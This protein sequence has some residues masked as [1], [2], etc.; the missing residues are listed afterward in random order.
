MNRKTVKIM[1]TIAVILVTVLF[2][3]INSIAEEAVSTE[4]IKLKSRTE[5]FN[6]VVTIGDRNF[7][8]YAQNSPEW[9]EIWV[10]K[11]RLATVGGNTCAAHSLANVLVN[12][13]PYEKLPMVQELA[14]YPIKI[15]TNNIS[16]WQGI[17]E[18]N[19]F[20]IKENADFFRYLPLAI[21]NV[22]TGNNSS[23]GSNTQ[24]GTTNYYK[25]Y[26]NK[27]GIEYKQ[28][29]DLK[30]CIDEIINNH[31]MVIVCTGSKSSPIANK[32]GHYFVMA[33]ATDDKVYFLDSIVRNEYK[34]DKKGY[35]HI[36]EP[37]VVWTERENV[38]NLCL[39]GTKFIIY[40]SEDATP[41]TQEKYESLINESNSLVTKH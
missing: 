30:E 14:P 19:S 13:A 34:L 10:G 5:S 6:R 38:K 40:P 11:G 31:A 22:A 20:E 32:Y 41:Y 37:G 9:D 33:Y 21:L 16:L 26:F 23:Y 24:F 4:E 28:T 2:I 18:E 8:F 15:D 17:K 1:V 3:A 39:F 7:V 27:M 12:C 36:D 29:Y 25:L 35:M